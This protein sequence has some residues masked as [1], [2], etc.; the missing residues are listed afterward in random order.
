MVN[1][2]KLKDG[3][4]NGSYYIGVYAI[5]DCAFTINVIVERELGG[6]VPEIEKAV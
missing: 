5:S 4:L 6:D 3:N 2:T 1:F